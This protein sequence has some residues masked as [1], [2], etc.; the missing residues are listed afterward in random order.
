MLS[1]LKEPAK[2]STAVLLWRPDGSG[3]E[4]VREVFKKRKSFSK[5]AAHQSAAA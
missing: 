3:V 1:R 4:E 5:R 2:K